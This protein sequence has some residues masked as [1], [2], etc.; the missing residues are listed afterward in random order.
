MKQDVEQDRDIETATQLT[1]NNIRGISVPGPEVE[2]SGCG[3]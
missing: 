1:L 2:N 3:V